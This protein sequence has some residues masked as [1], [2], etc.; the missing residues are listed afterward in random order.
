MLAT[1]IIIIIIICIHSKI[2]DLDF[3]I[4]SVVSLRGYKIN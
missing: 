1:T 4:S 2:H 3:P